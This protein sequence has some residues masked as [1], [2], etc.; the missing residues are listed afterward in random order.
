MTVVRSPTCSATQTYL[1]C[2]L[3]IDGVDANNL[4]PSPRP[5]VILIVLMALS[6]CE[7]GGTVSF[8]PLFHR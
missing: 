3:L 2:T 1:S 8:R 5:R 7:C 4:I 6:A